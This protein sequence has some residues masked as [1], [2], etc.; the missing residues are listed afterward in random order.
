MA[1]ITVN[2][3]S[4]TMLRCQNST[5]ILPEGIKDGSTIP[6]LW[7]LH[8][9]GDG[10][11]TWS[12][13]TS[14]ER[15]AKERGIAVVMPDAENS[16]YADMAHGYPFY[17]TIANELFDVMGGFF[18]LS[19]KR[20]D[21]WIAGN[22]MGGGG[23]LKIGLANPD[24]FSAI[25]CLSAGDTVFPFPGGKPGENPDVDAILKRVYDAR[26]TV[27]TEEDVLGNAQ[28]IVTDGLPAPR[29]Y[30]A[31]GKDDFLLSAAHRTRDFF[32]SLEGNPFDYTYVEDEGDHNWAY[33]DEHIVKFLDFVGV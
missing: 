12:R 1:Q 31:I 7:L 30:H 16:N 32:A 18:N 28:K 29:I 20:E 3:F 26:E 6:T 9:K 15:Y 23:A 11:T 5:V 27:G 4:S 10:H 25:G 2:W 22:S 24:R 21:N 17:R 8:G 19:D 14:I 13:N 33:W